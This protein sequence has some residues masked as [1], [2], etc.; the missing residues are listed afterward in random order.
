MRKK[1][2]FNNL[3]WVSDAYLA[4]RFGIARQTVWIWVKSGDFPRPKKLSAGCTRWY[5]PEIE[6]WDHE[7]RK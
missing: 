3:V 2:R 6:D 5:L 7:R 1:K 4:E